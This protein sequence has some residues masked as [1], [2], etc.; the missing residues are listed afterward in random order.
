MTRHRNLDTVLSKLAGVKPDG[1]GWTALCPAHDDKNPSLHVEIGDNGS[2]LL[3][4]RSRKCKFTAIVAALGMKQTDFAPD[5][6]FERESFDDWLAKITPRI[7]KAYDYRDSDGRLLYQ[8]LRLKS[9][10]EFIQR[11]PKGIGGRLLP[12]NTIEKYETWKWSTKGIRRVPYRFPELVAADPKQWI[13]IP[14]GEKDCDNLAGHGLLATTNAEGAGKW[15]TLDAE[16]LKMAF[17]GKRVCVIPDNDASGYQH[18][19]DV[20]KSIGGIVAEFRVLRLTG[21]GL[22]EDVS[23]WLEKQG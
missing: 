3:D 2:I 9:P 17:T 18:V 12:D 21:L 1:D 13:L 15:H 6:K 20:Y 23:D 10:K 5:G 19:L 7:D 14:E 8:V 22:K 4:C 11:R 16:A